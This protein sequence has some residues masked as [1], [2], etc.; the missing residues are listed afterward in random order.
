[1]DVRQID[2]EPSNKLIKDYLEQKSGILEFFDYP[3]Q[4][5][6]NFRLRAEE[7]SQRT[8]QRTELIDSLM[9]FNKRYT[10]NENVFQNI[11]KL[12]DSQAMAV[13]GGQQAGLLTGPAFSIHKCLS[14]IKMA[15]EQEKHLGVPVVPVFWIAGEDHDLDEVNHV[16]AEKNGF[17]RKK[18]LENI[19]VNKQPVSFLKLDQT[20]T[21]KWVKDVFHAY[22]ETEHTEAILEKIEEKLQQ[23]ETYVD[24]FAHLI[25]LLFE[26]EGLILMDSADRAFRGLE[27]NYF[28][29]MIE[30]N[31][32]INQSVVN[33]LSS[34]KE[35][36][37]TVQ[38]DQQETS[39]NL[40]Y[41]DG[42]GRVLLEREQGVF[43][44][45]G[46]GEKFTKD[47]LMQKAEALKL[48]NNVVTRP[49]MQDMLLP[50]L[51]FVAG[52]G[53]I[54]YW[55]ALG[56]AFHEMDI[57]MPLVV[58]R[59]HFTIFDRQTIKWLSEKSIGI[60]TL[61]QQEIKNVKEMWLKK[62]HPYQVDDVI[63]HY[64]KQIMENHKPLEQLM[65]EV[66]PGHQ[67]FSEKNLTI[68]LDHVE[69]FEKKVNQLIE[70]KYE[71]E[72]RRF[73]HIEQM[74]QPLNAPQERQWTIFYFINQYGFSL[75]DDLLTAEAAFNGKQHAIII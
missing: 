57:K 48:S 47:A 50:V 73:E 16:F 24:F 44:H 66:D 20:L 9:A 26:K 63:G 38:L 41:D 14:V 71:V 70:R 17:L 69:K 60:D 21:A 19:P 46:T 52:P 74:V 34:L 37:Y 5:S 2:H 29:Q 12:K 59:L 45:P 11:A 72:L 28:S 27:Q 40:F 61:F 1:M 4:D 51:A 8:Y 56:G 33:Q 43:S 36:G 65:S 15:R 23:S 10:N 6:R 7:I 67:A 64:K 25:Q 55:A 42:D 58:P 54:S 39:S 32:S 30:Q 13:V 49:I 62:E 22:G 18:V 53:E 68:L 3:C 31:E 75:I 35:E